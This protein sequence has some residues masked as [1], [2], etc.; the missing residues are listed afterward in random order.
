MCKLAAYVGNYIDENY[1][2]DIAGLGNEEST[3]EETE[4]EVTK[5]VEDATGAQLESV[6]EENIDDVLGDDT[7]NDSSEKEE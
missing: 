2:S 4:D 3:T 1:A 7:E 5:A 6:D